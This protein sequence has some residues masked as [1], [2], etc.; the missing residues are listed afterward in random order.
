MTALRQLF[1][2]LVFIVALAAQVFGRRQ[3]LSYGR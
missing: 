3:I 2:P 1:A